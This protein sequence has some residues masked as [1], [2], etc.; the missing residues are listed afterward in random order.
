MRER[1]ARINVWL[2]FLLSLTVVLSVNAELLFAQVNEVIPGIRE[3]G[4][5]QETNPTDGSVSGVTRAVKDAGESVSGIDPKQTPQYQQAMADAVR[6]AAMRCLDSVVSIEVIG[7]VGD[8]EGEV[9]RDAPGSGVIVDEAG[10]ILAS[11]LVISRPSA[12]LIVVLASGERHAAKVIAAD[13]H[14]DL[15]LLKIEAKEKLAAI[16]LSQVSSLQVGQ[17]V[18]AVGRYGETYSPLVSRG[19][20]S[21]TQ[22]LD[23]IALQCDARVS[24]SFYGG[25]L[26]DLY[27]RPLGVLIPAV[28]EGGAESSTSWYDSGIAF[29]IPVEVIARKL[30]RLKRGEGIKRGL[31][32]IVARSSDPY[33]DDTEI[34]AVRRRSPAEKA[35]LQQGD[36]IIRVA[37]R[38]VQRQ[39]EIR[40]ALGPYDAG[41]AISIEFLRGDETRKI[42][43]TLAGTIPPL[44]PQRIGLVLSNQDKSAGVEDKTLEAS[45]LVDP[46]ATDEQDEPVDEGQSTQ[47]G[48]IVVNAMVPGT[49]AEDVFQIGD[50]ILKVGDSAIQ[51]VDSLRRLLISLSPNTS[52]KVTVMRNAVLTDCEIES[53]S[54]ADDAWIRFPEGWVADEDSGDVQRGGWEINDWKLP[55]A[56]NAAALAAPKKVDGKRQL[57]LLIL[58]MNPGTG[59][60]ATVLE[61][62]LKAA[63]ECGVVV[64]AIAAEDQQRWL[65]KEVDVIGRFAT[66]MIKQFAIEPQ[67]VAISTL[68]ALAGGDGDAADSMTLAVALAQRQLFHGASVSIKARPPRIRLPENEGEGS[69]QLLLSLDKAETIPPWAKPLKKAG[70]PVVRAEDVDRFMLLRWVRLLQAI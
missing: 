25:V 43:V 32:G 2:T 60:P 67:A 9:E 15:V 69:F 54:I 57:G 59:A 27:G 50:E 68:G 40:Q 20:L 5:E 18:I 13:E 31:I 58:L 35:G 28:A 22:R 30:E 49:A 70:Y 8:G 14:R 10:Y 61:P 53:Q 65:P 52:L 7:A 11:S 45:R 3:S 29:A 39:L 26:I 16:D 4:S 56:G 42:E 63:E 44:E 23:G 64:C 6:N 12:S 55:E 34:A 48:S 38:A 33:A 21:A 24:P 19:I 62:W 66:S 17:T 51:D 47:D 37:E 46:P 41:E 36:K 1:R